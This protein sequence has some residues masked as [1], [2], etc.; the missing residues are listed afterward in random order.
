MFLSRLQN[1]GLADAIATADLAKLH[2]RI[3]L[4]GS[5]LP[6]K[7]EQQALRVFSQK[8]KQGKRVQALQEEGAQEKQLP[9]DHPEQLMLVLMQVPRI[10]TKIEVFRLIDH[11]H[12]R[13]ALQ[14]LQQKCQ[15]LSN[16]SVDVKGSVA[17]KSL[18]AF[19]FELGNFSK[20]QIA[21]DSRCSPLWSVVLPWSVGVPLL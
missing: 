18:V 12:D 16:A 17:I 7:E 4:L 21:C 6:N 8:Q 5:V 1:G 19:V 2:P 9:L 10:E 20:C 13:G 14:K 11:Y 15:T 3:E